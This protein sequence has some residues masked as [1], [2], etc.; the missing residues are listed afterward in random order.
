MTAAQ[1][2]NAPRSL[3][4]DRGVARAKRVTS[5]AL[6]FLRAVGTNPSKERKLEL[7]CAVR[8]YKARVLADVRNLVGKRVE[9]INPST[10]EGEW[11]EVTPQI[12]RVWCSLVDAL[13]A[14]VRT[15]SVATG[16]LQ[17]LAPITRSR[18]SNLALVS[19][20]TFTMWMPWLEAAGVL[21]YH[22]GRSRHPGIVGWPELYRLHLPHTRAVVEG[23]LR[24]TLVGDEDRWWWKPM[25]LALLESERASRTDEAAGDARAELAGAIVVTEDARLAWEA[26][27]TEVVNANVCR[28]KAKQHAAARAE[29]QARLRD[30]EVQREVEARKQEDA[31]ARE[32]RRR[33]AELELQAARAKLQA[34]KHEL[35]RAVRDQRVAHAIAVSRQNSQSSGSARNDPCVFNS[36]EEEFRST[37]PAARPVVGEKAAPAARKGSFFAPDGAGAVLEK[38]RQRATS[39]PVDAGPAADEEAGHVRPRSFFRPRL[40]PVDS[41]KRGAT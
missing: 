23:H 11:M 39:E 24:A 19:T 13:L 30:E 8:K 18:Q 41:T 12:A 17:P 27:K 33:V 35:E 21:L 6:S 40:V 28:S 14:N 38:L 36:S 25:C 15:F 29:T 34:Q 31:A 9:R 10:G 3:R 26:R 1:S 22:H 7:E 5:T 20:R 37:A 16:E 2:K 4:G 32:E